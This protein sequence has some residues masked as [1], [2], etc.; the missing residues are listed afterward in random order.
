[1]GFRCKPD[2][3][4]AF[5]MQ[6]D[7]GVVRLLYLECLKEIRSDANGAE[8]TLVDGTRLTGSLSGPLIDDTLL[9]GDTAFGEASVPIGNIAGVHV[10]PE[11]AAAYVAERLKEDYCH[12][13]DFSAYERNVLSPHRARV[14][15]VDANTIEVEQLEN[16]YSSESHGTAH[17]Y[18]LGRIV[19]RPTS[20]IFLRAEEFFTI[21]V[22]NQE[23]RIDFKR[24]RKAEFEHVGESID[25]RVTAT[26]GS[27]I[28]GTLYSG[29]GEYQRGG[30]LALWGVSELG[31]VY[32]PAAR[33]KSI[34]MLE[35]ISEAE[36]H[37][38]FKVGL[39]SVRLPF[40]EESAI[41]IIEEALRSESATV[42]QA[43]QE[44]VN[45]GKR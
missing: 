43:A 29:A 30:I 31:P 35:G 25:V 16:V 27:A 38:L 20:D 19:D 26:D 32:V 40:N 21:V 45:K 28:R 41:H 34:E 5:P 14:L 33:I 42:R 3:W 23:L 12:L 24:L 7:S 39:A 13:R 17:F 36:A 37:D 4:L 8:A 1:M 9:R 6:V 22:G 15:L 2:D 18:Y 11:V 10:N 44:A